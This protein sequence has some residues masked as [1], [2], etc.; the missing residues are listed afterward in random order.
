MLYAKCNELGFLHREVDLSCCV[1]IFR[2]AE[3]V[4]YSC[5][6]SAHS[7]RGEWDVA[8]RN[9][10][11]CA[12][13]IS[14]EINAFLLWHKPRASHASYW[15][16]LLPSHHALCHFRFPDSLASAVFLKVLFSF[17]LSV[18]IFILFFLRPWAIWEKI[19]SVLKRSVYCTAIKQVAHGLMF[20]IAYYHSTTYSVV[21]N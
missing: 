19:H 10:W 7:D 21:L 9:W 3:D 16:Q 2:L 6:R 18:C 5:W 1:L 17:F 14:V 12:W 15:D 8:S 20:R 13:D 11:V 4:W